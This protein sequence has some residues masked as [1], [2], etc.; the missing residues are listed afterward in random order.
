MSVRSLVAALAL[1]VLLAGSASGG[2]LLDNPNAWY[3][4]SI[5]AYWTGSTPMTQR[6]P[7]GH[8]RV[9]RLRARRLPRRRLHA[10]LQ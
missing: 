10:R 2:I 8:R 5:G 3:D 7:V 1:T 9:G 6:R 4:P